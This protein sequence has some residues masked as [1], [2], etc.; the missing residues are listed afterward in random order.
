MHY[1]VKYAHIVLT[2][3]QMLTRETFKSVNVSGAVVGR[4]W[5]R[6]ILCGEW[7][8]MGQGWKKKGGLEDWCSGVGIIIIV[9]RF[10][11]CHQ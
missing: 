11:V 10:T 8:Q 2:S 3:W 9:C 5:Q 4:T 6:I 1:T 7:E